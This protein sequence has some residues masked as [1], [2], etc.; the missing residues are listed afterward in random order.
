[1]GSGKAKLICLDT[2]VLVD[3]FRAKGNRSS[4]VLRTLLNHGAEVLIVP[5]VAAGEF[6]DGA[7]MVSNQRLQEA[8]Q[9][10]RDRQVVPINLEIA[11]QYGRLSAQLRQA[12]ALGKRSQNDLWIGA[13][14][15]CHG[16]RLMTRNPDDFSGI[17]GLEILTYTNL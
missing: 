6:L 12:G 9:L 2:T 1:M 16:A 8:L 7:A 11:E 13:T 15:R 3:E 14:A 10:M 17:F 4:S 5:V